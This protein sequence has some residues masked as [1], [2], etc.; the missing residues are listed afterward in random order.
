MRDDIVLFVRRQVLSC[1]PLAAGSCTA[2][3]HTV[4]AAAAVAQPQ[5][6]PYGAALRCRT[7]YRSIGL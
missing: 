3:S 5:P 4:M 6:G 7:C 1:V 2:S